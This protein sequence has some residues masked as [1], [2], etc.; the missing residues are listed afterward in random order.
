M[1]TAEE[2]TA[3]K[4]KLRDGSEAVF[5]QQGREW[6]GLTELRCVAPKAFE[7]QLI[8]TA[9]EPDSGR[10]SQLFHSVFGRVA[11]RVVLMASPQIGATL[12][13]IEAAEAATPAPASAAGENTE[14]RV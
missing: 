11:N 13:A 10:M 9:P 6:N 3:V 4:I 14:G 5:V 1:L 2:I 7:G 12:K 8:I